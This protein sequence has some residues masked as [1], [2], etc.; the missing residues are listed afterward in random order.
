MALSVQEPADDV[1]AFLAVFAAL[2][3]DTVMRFEETA[4]SVSNL[5][6]AD[7]NASR[8]LI[9][10]LQDFDRLKQEFESLGDALARYA[11]ATNETVP[12]GEERAKLGRDVIAEVT[13]A[14]LKERLL[15]RLQGGSDEPVLQPLPPLVAPELDCDFVF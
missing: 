14:D 4:S 10:A 9:V 7:G 13:L 2:L 3:L 8:P 12:V 1:G 11:A 5:V 15:Q 6:A